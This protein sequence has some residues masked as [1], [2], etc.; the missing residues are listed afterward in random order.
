LF[1]KDKPFLRNT[2]K[3]TYTKNLGYNDLTIQTWMYTD[4]LTRQDQTKYVTVCELLLNVQ[5][6]G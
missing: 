2:I 6:I 4:K 5:R 3:Y 1:R